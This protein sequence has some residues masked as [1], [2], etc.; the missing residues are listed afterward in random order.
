MDRFETKHYGV[1]SSTLAKV[2]THLKGGWKTHHVV[3]NLSYIHMKKTTAL[4]QYDRIESFLWYV[5][6][7]GYTPK[8]AL[9]TMWLGRW[10]LDH[11]KKTF[12]RFKEAIKQA[13][14]EYKERRII[15]DAEEQY[16]DI[17]TKVEFV[18]VSE[19]RPNIFEQI[20]LTAI[21][22]VCLL[23]VIMIAYAIYLWCTM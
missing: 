2:P 11:I 4:E 14:E 13:Q 22:T 18:E 21:V 1:A 12:P 17:E 10:R 6:R 15:E 5:G 9:Q 20:V 8:E 16:Y 23:D 19:I 7:Y 3:F